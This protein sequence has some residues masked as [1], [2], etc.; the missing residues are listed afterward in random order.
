MFYTFTKKMHTELHSGLYYIIKK[1]AIYCICN[2]NEFNK[3]INYILI[4]TRFYIYKCR[5]NNKELNI[6]TWVKEMKFFLHIEKKI[7]IKTDRFDKFAKYW[8]KWM[9]IFNDN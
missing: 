9:Q 8:Q 2:Q 4:L 5:I 3:P 6:A 1:R 7:A